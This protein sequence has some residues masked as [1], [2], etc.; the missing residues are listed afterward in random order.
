M[1]SG[2]VVTVAAAPATPSPSPSPTL[3]ITSNP[4]P[5]L[6]STSMVDAPTSGGTSGSLPLILLLLAIG[7]AGLAVLS[8]LPRR[9]RR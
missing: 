6:P 1:Q 8:P 9:A 2:P 7:S 4:T 3:P 5:T